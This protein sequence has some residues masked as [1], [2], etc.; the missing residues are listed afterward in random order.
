MKC[1]SQN[2]KNKPESQNGV[3]GVELTV[4]VQESFRFKVVRIRIH[5]LIMDHGPGEVEAL[6]V[7]GSQ[8]RSFLPDI[9][10]DHGSWS[11]ISIFEEP[12]E[13]S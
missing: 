5:G 12:G 4:R 9:G 13:S 3:I 6:L 2:G 8:R 7:R 1:T 11:N 10:E